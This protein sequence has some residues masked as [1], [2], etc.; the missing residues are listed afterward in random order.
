MKKR[1]SEKLSKLCRIIKQW[2]GDIQAANPNMWIQSFFHKSKLGR[3][4]PYL[5]LP[6]RGSLPWVDL[7]ESFKSFLGVRSLPKCL[8][9]V[10]QHLFVSNGKVKPET[11]TVMDTVYPAPTHP[12]PA[13]HHIGQEPPFP[14]TA[15]VLLESPREW[16][17]SDL[18]AFA[19]GGSG[20][21][22]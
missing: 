16:A 18:V 2:L 1:D 13:L 5:W 19:P 7:S 20:A 6:G 11:A 15:H 8:P 22:L 10:A 9:Q 12:A 3:L 21:Q 4:F 17:R 14:Y